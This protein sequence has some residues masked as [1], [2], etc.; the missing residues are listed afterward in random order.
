MRIIP[1]CLL[2]LLNFAPNLRAASISELE[3]AARSSSPARLEKLL[4]AGWGHSFREARRALR[5]GKS[6]LALHSTEPGMIMDIRSPDAFRDTIVSQ[7]LMGEDDIGHVWVSWRCQTRRGIVEGAAGQTGNFDDQF[8]ELLKKGWGLAA[9]KA[10]FTDGYVETPALIEAVEFRWPAPFHTLFVE[11]DEATCGRA[12]KFVRDYVHH[13]NKPHLR[14]GLE[15]NPFN[16]EG[17]GCGSFGLAVAE[18]A[19]L[20]GSHRVSEN[21]WRPLRANHEL[22]GFG[23]PHP[24]DVIPFNLV[25]EGK[26]SV[27]LTRVLSENWN[28][29]DAARD[30][31]LRVMDPELLLL[32]LKT[33][34]RLK[35]RELRAAG[36]ERLRK[37]FAAK[38]PGNLWAYRTTRNET[39]AVIDAGFDAA[40]A[41]VVDG[42]T[43]WLRDNA[44]R[45]RVLWLGKNPAVV[46]EKP[47]RR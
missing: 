30:P 19:G 40:S 5:P 4:N 35:E 44:F 29:T 46:L 22:F 21:F 18:V 36:G 38:G 33:I 13:P 1:V 31:Q 24:A 11:V 41:R 39:P 23:L 14:Y 20:F 26:K 28:G 10:H 45:T 6:Y 27:S 7:A 17:G 32:S 12:M 15:A 42:T 9:F 25:P 16:F 3:K 2:V 37:L 8:L 43:A 47:A 34:Y